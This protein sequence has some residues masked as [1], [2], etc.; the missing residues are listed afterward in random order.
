MS[1]W[2][3]IGILVV[4]IC[5]NGAFAMSEVALIASRRARLQR[6]AEDNTPGAKRAADLNADPNRALSTIQVGITSIGLLSGIFGESALAKPVAEWLMT[7]GVGK[8]TASALGIGLVVVLLTYFSIVLG[9]L[10]PK[11]VGLTDPERL[12]C[13]VSPILNALSVIAAPFVKLLSSSTSGILKLLRVDT[14]R[15]SQVTE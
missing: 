15:Q 13:R 8:E 11:R 3:D 12:A 10:V 9:E 6:M 1:S 7:L 2:I 5:M 14:S 4:L